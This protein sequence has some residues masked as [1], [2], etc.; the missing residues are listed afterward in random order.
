VLLAASHL[1]LQQSLQIHLVGQHPSARG[2]QERHTRRAP[3]GASKLQ[4][5]KDDRFF[6][7]TPA[8]LLQQTS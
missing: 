5:A 4:G 8:G 1:H 3:P 2:G 7:A 6:E